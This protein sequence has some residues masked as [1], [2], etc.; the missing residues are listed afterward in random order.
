MKHATED[1]SLFGIDLIDEL[2]EEYL[3]PDNSSEDSE[4]FAGSIGMISCL[5]SITE[6]ADYEEVHNLPNSEDNNND[7]SDLEFEAE[8]FE[9]LDQACNL[10]NSECSAKRGQDE[11]KTGVKLAEQLRDKVD[12]L[13]ET[14]LANED[15]KQ[16]GAKLILP[17]GSDPKAAQRPEADSNPTRTEDTASPTMNTNKEGATIA[18]KNCPRV[19]TP[20]LPYKALSR[21]P[22]QPN[23]K[24]LGQ[25][26]VTPNWVEIESTPVVVRLSLPHLSDPILNSC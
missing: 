11:E 25:N 22:P 23:L 26:L 18:P 6:E 19:R 21:P 4:K 7:I 17:S 9:V 20:T 5:G 10:E 15:Q 1:H 13:A 12:M 3:Q 24:S 16:A 2:V 14:I 8:L